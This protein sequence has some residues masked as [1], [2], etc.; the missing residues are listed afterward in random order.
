[1]GKDL[2]QILP[3]ISPVRAD[4]PLVRAE[5]LT[6]PFDHRMKKRQWFD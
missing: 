3:P 4:I 1:M 6:V 2:T 5:T